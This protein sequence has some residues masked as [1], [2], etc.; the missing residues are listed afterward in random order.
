VTCLSAKDP[1]QSVVSRFY[2]WRRAGIW[3]R[4]LAAL[5]RQADA[6]GRLDWSTHFVDGTSIR[7]HQHAAGAASARAGMLDKRLGGAAAGTARHSTSAPNAA[8]SH[9]FFW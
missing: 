8:A 2:R 6:H 1:G 4:L 3:Q 5:Q 9:S 7:A